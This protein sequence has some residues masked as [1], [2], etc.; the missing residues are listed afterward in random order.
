MQQLRGSKPNSAPSL[1]YEAN[2]MTSLVSVGRLKHEVLK[3]T[4]L[5]TIF[6]A[7]FGLFSYSSLFFFSE[8]SH[9]LFIFVHYCFVLLFSL[10][11]LCT[12]ANVHLLTGR[13]QADEANSAILLCSFR[14][15]ASLR[16]T[17]CALPQ[18]I[19]LSP[20]AMRCGPPKKAA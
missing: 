18:V 11:S 10:F 13:G 14:Q 2:H 7:F 15:R 19:L 16:S 12:E 17:S 8:F 1:G 20:E 9:W 4:P 3:Q 5:R 6:R